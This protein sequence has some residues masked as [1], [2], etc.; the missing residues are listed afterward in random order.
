MDRLHAKICRSGT[1][2][3]ARDRRSYFARSSAGIGAVTDRVAKRKN[4]RALF[5]RLPSQDIQPNACNFD[6]SR[7]RIHGRMPSC[8]FIE[9][10]LKRIRLVPMKHPVLTALL[11]LGTGIALCLATSATAED[12]AVSSISLDTENAD[13]TSVG[14]LTWR[15]GFSIA[16][17]DN[18]FGGLSAL[19]VSPDGQRMLALT[20]RGSWVKASL[21]YRDGM[22][23]GMRDI[24]ITPLLDLRGKPLTGR[25]SDSEALA[26]GDGLIVSFERQHR[27]WRYK[28]NASGA[29]DL[30]RPV[31]TPID[32]YRL[33]D[34]GGIEAMTRLCDG[35]LLIL[36]EKAFDQ[37]PGVIGWV[38]SASGWQSFRYQT[39]AAL[40]P[41]GAATLPNCD[42]AFVDRSFSLIAGLDIRLTRLRPEEIQPGATVVPEELAH[43]SDPLS[44]DNFEGIAARRGEDGE[45]LI[46]LVSDDNFNSVQR[47]L[48]VMFELGETR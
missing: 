46:Y 7:L 5:P 10:P 24:D 21:T 14:Q 3:A 13:R 41:T 38:Q 19:Q 39:K 22:L 18:R 8:L 11:F 16:G 42:I 40:R 27:L 26:N 4:T 36:A 48:L 17:G 31:K 32:L 47:T 37:Q 1:L 6:Y 9:D 43:L 35:R 20:D 25:R 12:Y 44:I 2:F 30:P 45:T 29:F 34:N 15:G 23:I 33:S 28:K